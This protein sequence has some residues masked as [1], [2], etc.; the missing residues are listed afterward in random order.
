MCVAK[1]RV[2]F[3]PESR[4]RLWREIEFPPAVQALFEFFV[5]R[6]AIKNHAGLNSRVNET[7]FFALE[8]H[9]TAVMT[10]EEINVLPV[11]TARALAPHEMR[12]SR[13]ALDKS[14]SNT[15]RGANASA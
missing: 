10:T 12:N 1:R 8:A 11:L 2:R 5:Q 15:K 3:T 9:F 7:L 6:Q 13:S 14:R 4:Q